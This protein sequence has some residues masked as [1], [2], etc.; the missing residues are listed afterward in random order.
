MGGMV[1]VAH[2]APFGC[3][4]STEE[5]RRRLFKRLGV[6][7][8]YELAAL[9]MVNPFDEKAFAVDGKGARL[10]RKGKGSR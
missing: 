4:A 7:S 1:T 2:R 9:L 3:W 5:E 6:A 8:A 10:W